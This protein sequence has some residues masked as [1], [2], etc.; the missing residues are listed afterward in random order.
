MFSLH[1]KNKKNDLQVSQNFFF[2][3]ILCVCIDASLDMRREKC[4]LL[5]SHNGFSTDYHI[6]RPA[7]WSGYAIAV[8]GRGYRGLRVAHARHILDTHFLRGLNAERGWCARPHVCWARRRLAGGNGRER[9]PCFLGDLCLKFS[10]WFGRG[11][12]VV[13]QAK[14][15]C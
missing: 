11:K 4:T 9:K 14:R 7:P 6:V 5:A 13:C 8:S 12:G 10:L 15:L 3:I 2:V 1:K